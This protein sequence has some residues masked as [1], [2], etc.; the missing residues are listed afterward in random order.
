MRQ[1]MDILPCKDLL[2]SLLMSGCRGLTFAFYKEVFAFKTIGCRAGNLGKRLDRT[3][4]FQPRKKDISQNAFWQYRHYPHLQDAT[5]NASPE[6]EA[7][8]GGGT[9]VV[10]T[11]DL[12]DVSEAL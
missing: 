2:I 1:A 11:Q 4:V 12:F 9:T 8:I 3:G 10:R 7:L 6:R 5:K